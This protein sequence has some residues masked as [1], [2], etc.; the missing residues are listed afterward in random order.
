MLFLIPFFFC[1]CVYMCM[2][3][4]GVYACAWAHVCGMYACTWVLMDVGA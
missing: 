3:V 2:P 1:A 4:G